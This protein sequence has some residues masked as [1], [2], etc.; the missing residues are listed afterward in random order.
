MP[1]SS[2][3]LWP[4]PGRDTDPWFVTFEAMVSAMDASGF[5]AREDR[6]LIMANGGTFTFDAGGDLILWD[7]TLEII[8]PVS[9]FKHSMIANSATLTDGEFLYVDLIRTSTGNQTVAPLVATNVPSTDSAYAICGRSGDTVYFRNGVRLADGQSKSLFGPSFGSS[10]QS[11][12]SILNLACRTTHTTEVPLV[13]GAVSLD[14]SEYDR[15]GLNVSLVFRVLAANTEPG[16]TTHA[17]LV[18]VTDSEDVVEL[19]FTST[20]ITKQ[21]AVLVR[22]SGTGQIDD[23]PHVYEVQV[24]LDVAPGSPSETMEIYSGEIRVLSTIP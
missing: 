1:N 10:G 16:M 4:Y 5:A 18:N 22:G 21:E 6:H 9:G 13:I 17:K 15:Q 20:E 7:D 8:S 23:A 14:P 24:Y 12:I 19:D 11:E 2:R 3:M